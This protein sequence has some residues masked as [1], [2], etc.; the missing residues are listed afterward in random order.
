MAQAGGTGQPQHT[1]GQIFANAVNYDVT[2]RDVE[3]TV[4]IGCFSLPQNPS[5][6]K[7]HIAKV[8]QNDAVAGRFREL[9]GK[10][11]DYEKS[12]AQHRNFLEYHGEPEEPNYDLFCVTAA[13]SGVI[14]QRT[15]QLEQEL[16]REK[17]LPY[18][19]DFRGLANPTFY[20][21]RF[22]TNASAKP[23]YLCR[24]LR[25]KA[26]FKT[27][28]WHGFAAFSA[29]GVLDHVLDNEFI[30]FFEDKVDFIIHDGVCFVYHKDPVEKIFHYRLEL[31]AKVPGA[32]TKITN[33]FPIKEANKWLQTF[34][35]NT[36]M[37]ASLIKVS[38]EPRLETLTND[39]LRQ[40]A[41]KADLAVTW[42]GTAWDIKNVWHFLRLL[43]DNVA[44]T[45]NYRDTIVAG[46]KHVVAKPTPG[47]AANP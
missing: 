47:L 31:Q 21:V 8:E 45:E 33:L 25:P 2:S 15:S 12:L 20:A 37:A 18:R 27:W 26:Y 43:G 6:A 36:T 34:N 40:T 44:I 42:D 35:S 22:R 19:R 32:F 4:T 39:Q 1:I 24:R 10:I 16:G 30:F 29:Q 3:I 41:E 46:A 5:N 7:F 9:S 23:L 13:D 38:E 28:T 17:F 11:L 14:G